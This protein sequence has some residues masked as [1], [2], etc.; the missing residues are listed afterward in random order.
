MTPLLCLDPSTNEIYASQS[1]AENEVEAKLPNTFEG[2][3]EFYKP[4]S[5]DQI[6]ESW[7]TFQKS[8]N[9]VLHC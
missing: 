5:F 6:I 2:P 3:M 7:E 9:L 4:L 1:E 8:K